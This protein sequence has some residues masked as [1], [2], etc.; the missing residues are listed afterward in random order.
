MDRSMNRSMDRSVDRCAIYIGPEQ[1]QRAES[2]WCLHEYRALG[3]F[4]SVNPDMLAAS[5]GGEVTYVSSIGAKA[6][7]AVLRFSSIGANTIGSEL[8]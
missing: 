3:Q 5:K 2:L 7:G 1:R 4:S 6:I 8:P